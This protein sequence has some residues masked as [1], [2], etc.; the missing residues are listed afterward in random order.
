MPDATDATKPAESNRRASV[1]RVT[2]KSP[3][4]LVGICEYNRPVLKRAGTINSEGVG[5]LEVEYYGESGL[6]ATAD[7]GLCR[8]CPVGRSTGIEGIPRKFCGGLAHHHGAGIAVAVA[9]QHGYRNV[10]PM[11]EPTETVTAVI[12][13]PF[14]PQITMPAEMDLVEKL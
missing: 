13:P 4:P 12:F 5:I 2:V 1:L 10:Y 8:C 9:Y 7:G 6:Q 11:T 3:A 14:L